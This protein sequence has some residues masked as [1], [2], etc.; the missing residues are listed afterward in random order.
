MTKSIYTSILLTTLIFCACEPKDKKDEEPKTIE[1]ELDSSETSEALEAI[2]VKRDFLAKLEG[3]H[4][5]EYMSG[6]LGAN[7]M[8]DYQ[9]D[10]GNWSAY[11]SSNNGGTREGYDIELSNEDLQKL[12]TMKI[13][14]APN[15]SISVVCEDKTYFT[16]PFQENKLTYL[17]E[18]S[19]EDFI[20]GVPQDLIESTT[21]FKGNLYLF[22]RDEIPE[23]EI[24]PID[25]AGAWAD[26]AVL[27]C[28]S[29]SGEFQLNLFFGECCD[30]ST[31][32]F[33]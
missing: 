9:L 6:F 1:I 22:A 32:L 30:N 18:N 21:F 8:V 25:I 19:P 24:K 26:A 16:I 4:T 14:V 5:L 7:T 33:K 12:T 3:E 23:S 11:G 28:D 31:Y 10:E 15:L 13:I 27:S 20:I 17:L 2:T 29:V